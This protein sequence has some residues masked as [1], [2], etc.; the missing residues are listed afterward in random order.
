V[1]IY[2]FGDM[3]S[4]Q[5]S[6]PIAIDLYGLLVSLE[7]LERERKVEESSQHLHYILMVW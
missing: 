7:E 1:E 3:Q 5:H 6:L 4:H 2:I